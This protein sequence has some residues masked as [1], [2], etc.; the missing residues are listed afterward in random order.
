MALSRFFSSNL[1][2]LT[3]LDHETAW[4]LILTVKAWNSRDSV[5]SSSWHFALVVVS[6]VVSFGPLRLSQ[7][8]RFR[9]H[10]IES[11]SLRFGVDCNARVDVAFYLQSLLLLTII[12]RPMVAHIPCY[13]CSL[14]T[15][16]L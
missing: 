2:H 13:C 14:F 10:I 12:G 5:S 16:R 1:D 15:G 3:A 9:V 6:A 7:V 11:D 4:C 8:Y